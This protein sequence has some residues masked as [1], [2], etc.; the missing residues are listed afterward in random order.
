MSEI[1]YWC[2]ARAKAKAI[3]ISSVTNWAI[4][5]CSCKVTWKEDV[6]TSW[7]TNASF[8][9]VVVAYFSCKPGTQFRRTHDSTEEERKYFMT[10][11]WIIVSTKRSSSRGRGSFMRRTISYSLRYI[12]ETLNEK[13][14]KQLWEGRKYAV[15][16]YRWQTIVVNM[17][18]VMLPRT[19]YVVLVVQLAL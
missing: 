8:F 5:L 14:I 15:V 17:G 7:Y 16:N 10:P 12:N 6:Q 13:R 3:N 19:T 2:Y 9:L 4:F 18:G 11:F 1:F